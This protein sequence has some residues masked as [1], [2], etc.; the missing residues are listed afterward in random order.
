MADG[1]ILNPAAVAAGGGGG[2]ANEI[3]LLPGTSQ[4]PDTNACALN[5]TQGTNIPFLSLDFD[6]AADEQ[7]YWVF[8]VPSTWVGN[9]T[10]TIWWKAAATT[11]DVVWG[12]ATRAIGDGGTW[13]STWTETTGTDTVKG[14]TEQLNAAAIV[15]TSPWVAGDTGQVRIRRLGSNGSDTMAGDA[16]CVAVKLSW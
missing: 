4:L 14:T 5:R 8:E 3:A 6:A 16:K 12:A 15:I 9:V 13:D 10:V 2:G 1:L 11:G 7:A